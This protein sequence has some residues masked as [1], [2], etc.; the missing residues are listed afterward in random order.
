MES[1]IEILLYILMLILLLIG[2]AFFSSS[3]TAFSS[4]NIIKLRNEVKNNK[5]KIKKAKIIYNM[6]NNF[7]RYLITILVGNNIVNILLPV[8]T[9]TFMAK[10]FN[11]TA[12]A[13]ATAILTIL[14]IIF[15]EIIPKS[16][17]SSNSIA[18]SLFTAKALYVID[19]ILKPITHLLSVFQ[20]YFEKLLGN[21]KNEDNVTVTEKEL[22]QIVQAIES[23]GV[24][25][26][27]ERELIESAIAFTDVK[28]RDVMIPIEEVISINPS[29]TKEKVVELFTE[30]KYSRIP[31]LN[32]KTQKI[33]G[34]LYEREFLLNY[35]TNKPTSIKTI[36]KDPF[37]VRKGAKIINVLEDL[38]RNKAHMAIVIDTL[39][40][41]NCVGIITLEDI[42]E[43][44][45]GEI[46][47]E[48]DNLPIDVVEIGHHNYEVSGHCL[49][50]ILFDEYLENAKRPKNKPFRV[51]QWVQSLANKKIRVNDV[52]YYDNL[53]IKILEIENDKLKKVAIEEF[54]P[55]DNFFD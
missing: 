9:T 44:L 41:K 49:L 34:I 36:M 22:V 28:V 23:E 37:F 15:G 46:Y 2:S 51:S 42:L 6:Q 43:E 39:K 17:A 4:I 47:D 54:T 3:E 52:L 8:V 31:V 53:E 21:T 26:Q 48:Y 50:D 30:H 13:V 55:T 5:K 14:V 24:L 27:D 16:Y 33:I 40:N 12:V 18:V 32:K 11:S 38:Q 1:E 35:I 19:I 45:V 20:N 25:D 29:S 10:Y 7:S